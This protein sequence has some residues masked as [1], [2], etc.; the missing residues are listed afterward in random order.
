MY[1]MSGLYGTVDYLTK[2][3]S[4]YTDIYKSECIFRERT[5]CDEDVYDLSCIVIRERGY[6]L[7]TDPEIAVNLYKDLTRE[8]P[9]YLTWFALLSSMYHGDLVK[10]MS[11]T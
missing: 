10:I 5:P 2:P 4:D 11:D 1:Y 7:P 9:I 8:I 3:H 6:A